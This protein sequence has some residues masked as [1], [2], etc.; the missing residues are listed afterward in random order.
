MT[1]AIAGFFKDPLTRLCILIIRGRDITT[2][3]YM[4]E[5]PSLN[6]EGLRMRTK[7]TK[8]ITLKV[9]NNPKR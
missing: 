2:S 5:R 4:H 7:I 6:V 3:D 8:L 1:I 9:W